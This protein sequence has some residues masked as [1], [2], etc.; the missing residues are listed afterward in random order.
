MANRPSPSGRGWPEGPSEGRAAAMSSRPAAPLAALRRLSPRCGA[1]RD[2]AVPLAAPATA[3]ATRRRASPHVRR[4]SPHY[5]AARHTAARLAA[6][7]TPRATPRRAS[8][9]LQRVP[10]H[11]GASRRPRRVSRRRRADC[12]NARRLLLDG[13][14]R[15]ADHRRHAALP[16]RDHR[17][18]G[19]WRRPTPA[20]PS[21]M[22]TLNSPPA[23][24]PH[25]SGFHEAAGNAKKGCPR[26]PSRRRGAGRAITGRTDFRSCEQWWCSP[27]SQ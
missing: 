18:R 23:F 20:S 7:A 5:G 25:G 11:C 12:G 2:T 6:V 15:P 13:V 4:L 14:V 24:R 27:E 16:C 8:P 22:S 3:L 26:R 21:R 19:R 17:R 1:A 10:P 9:H